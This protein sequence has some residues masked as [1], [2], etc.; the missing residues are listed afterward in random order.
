[1]TFICVFELH[2]ESKVVQNS[3]RTLLNKLDGL[4]CPESEKYN[5]RSKGKFSRENGRP[6]V[7]L[8]FF[9]SEPR[10]YKGNRPYHGFR[11]HF[12]K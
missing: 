8:H 6:L 10:G 11:R 2:T 3:L 12:D 4:S 1:M 7:A 9:H 5:F